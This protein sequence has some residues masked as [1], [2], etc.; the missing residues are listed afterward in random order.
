ML[1]AADFNI[2]DYDF[3][4]K[5]ESPANFPLP[6]GVSLDKE[7]IENLKSFELKMY[8]D[9]KRTGGNSR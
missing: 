2:S 5:Q 9:F 6:P 8:H 1:R 3:S 4:V 7:I